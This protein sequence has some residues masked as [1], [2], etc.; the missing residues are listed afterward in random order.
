MKNRT[1]MRAFAAL[2]VVASAAAP[3]ALRAQQEGGASSA[4]AEAPVLRVHNYNWLDMHIYV[5]R[6]SGPLLSLGVVTTNSTM[7]FNLPDD[8]TG[9]DAGLRVVADPIGDTGVW[10]SPDILV[11]PRSDVVLDLENS[12]PLSHVS[13][14]PKKDTP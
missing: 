11:G 1:M 3:H 13:I 7:T 5:S 6:S 12:L 4:P 14:E 2:A 8:V 9:A 10:V